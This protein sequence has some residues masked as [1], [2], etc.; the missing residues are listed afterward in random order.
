MSRTIEGLVAGGLIAGVVWYARRERDRARAAAANAEQ[1]ARLADARAQLAV[2]LRHADGAVTAGNAAGNAALAAAQAAHAARLAQARGELAAAVRHADGA[3]AA[4]NAAGA[5]TSDRRLADAR[6]QL[7]EAVRRA[8][9]A[10]AAGNAAGAA[11][12]TG[13]APPAPAAP[14]TPPPAPASTSRALTRRFDALFLRHGRGIPVAYLRALADAESG[15]NPDDRL[16]LIN[17]V[18]KT[19]DDY[20]RRHPEAPIAHAR[21]RDPATNIRVA[22][23]ILR[24]MIDSLHRHHPDVRNLREDWTNPRFVELATQSWNSGHSER[25]GVGRVVR[26]LKAQ[27]ASRRPAE[28]TVDTIYEAAID[29]Q[30][31]KTLSNPRK[32]DFAK[33]VT[34]A[35]L[36]ER[37]RDAREGLAVTT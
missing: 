30:A 21:M 12:G 29:A 36:R 9:G 6:E 34:T 8:D 20:N 1:V 7:A 32:R 19:L 22:A 10:I 13:Q 31:A 14:P 2:A 25:A 17:V 4:G 3:I 5:A 23:D 15:L 37:A 11:V 26:Y 24:E 18:P 28:I 35:Y 27:P 16:G 33:R